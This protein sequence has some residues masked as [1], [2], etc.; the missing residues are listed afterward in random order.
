MGILG[1]VGIVTLGA[2]VVWETV[3]KG[4]GMWRA[5]R[6]NELGWFIGILIFNT[7]GILP[8]IYL[9]FFDKKTRKKGRRKRKK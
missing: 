6:R 1:P 2:L 5:A 7:I 3:W 9:V 4:I 8:L